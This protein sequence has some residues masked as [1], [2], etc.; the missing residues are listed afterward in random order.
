M[1]QIVVDGSLLQCPSNNC[2]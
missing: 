2:Y 1:Y